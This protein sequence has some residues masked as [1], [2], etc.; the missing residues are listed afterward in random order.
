[1]PEA[2]I[3]RRTLL[4][5]G[6]TAA[7]AA[8]LPRTPAFARSAPRQRPPNIVYI[9]AD[10]LGY[11]A[12]GCYGQSTLRTP[13]LDRLA[14]EGLRFTDGYSSAPMCAPSRCCFL[15]GMHNGHAR[16]RDNTF[17]DT[18]IQPRLLPE[19]VTVAE[20][21]RSAGYATGIFG[22]WGFGDDDA[23]VA[24][25]LTTPGCTPQ[26]SDP[27]PGGPKGDL[28]ANA[29]D[30][31]HPLQKGFDEF[32]GLVLHDQSTAGYYPNYIWDGNRRVV[33][34]ENK[35]EARKTYAPDL[36]VGRA[37]EFIERH[38][39]DTFFLLVTPQLVHWPNLVPSTEPYQDMPWTEDVK[40]YAAMHTRL[41]M[42]VGQIRAQ[43]ERLGLANDTLLVFTSDNGPTEAE[44]LVYGSGDCAKEVGPSPDSGLADQLWQT[45]G[46]LR[47]S[48]HSLYEGGYRVPMIAWGPGI[49]RRDGGSAVTS[50]PWASWD[51]LPTFADIAGVTAPSDIDGVSVRSWIT[52][53]RRPSV[54]HPTLYW[55]RPPYGAV[56]TDG[57]RPAWMTYGEAARKGRWKGLRFAPGTDPSAPRDQWQFEL[58]DLVADRQERYNVAAL[59]PDLRDQLVSFMEASHK[60]PPYGRK[61]YSPRATHDGFRWR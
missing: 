24:P 25:G 39:A 10:D 59:H 22:K 18:H 9:L 5:T 27:P 6:A 2:G 28:S 8:L 3:T 42:Y 61:P 57:S 12:L 41:D 45:T 46:G 49:V 31:S 40:R 55:E 32:V 29:R 7:A 21:M 15:T 34:P 30:P 50:R 47:G 56:N 17:T 1:M 58:Y 60:P 52:G 20:V 19:D 36:Y 4:G 53:E 51:M 11:G 37:L 16:V 43:L 13:N 26:A 48:K 23:Y 35:G 54:D 38:R 33:L 44:R 14:A